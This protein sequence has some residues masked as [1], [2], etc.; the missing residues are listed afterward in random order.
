[1]PYIIACAMTE[2]SFP[3]AAEIP[4]EEARYRVGKNSAGI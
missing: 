2:P 3:E 4:C 1:M